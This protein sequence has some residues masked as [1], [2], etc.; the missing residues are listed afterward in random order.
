MNTENNKIYI[1]AHI[2]KTG[3]TT[4][5]HHFIKYMKEHFDF[6]HLAKKGNKAAVAAGLLAFEERST[7]EME[8]IK[9]IIGHKVNMDT[10]L[11]FKNKTI[12]KI[13][14]FRNPETWLPSRY[15]QRMNRRVAQGKRVIS[16]GNWLETPEPFFSQFNWLIAQY[17]KFGASHKKLSSNQIYDLIMNNI[18][19]FSKIFFLETLDDQIIQV[20]NE[21]SIPHTLERKNIT[22]IEKVNYL[23]NNEA[24]QEIIS[25][26]I[27]NDLIL[28]ND[29]KKY[30]T[31]Y[32]LL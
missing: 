29:V 21:L 7:S 20:C 10:G 15:N 25:D 6:V 28:F 8:N 32:N 1:F 5:R 19:E 24:E 3:G 17:Y 16:L 27:Q 9:V 31:S 4:L 2:S 18:S 11:Y 22:G 30:A 14:T 23:E 26:F 13:V 12:N